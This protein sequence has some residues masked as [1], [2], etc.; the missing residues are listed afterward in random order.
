MSEYETLMNRLIRLSGIERKEIEAMPFKGF[1]VS[2]PEYEVITPQTKMS[3]HVRSLNVSEEE[4]LKGSLVTPQ[5]VTEHLNK[6][7]F[8]SIVKKPETITDFKSFLTQVTLK[9]R[10]A[11][12]YGLY[13]ITY[14]EI[15]NYDIR[16]VACRKTFP[17]TVRASSTFNINLYPGNDILSKRVKV[18][19]PVTTGVNAVIRQPRL[20]DEERLMRDLAGVSIDIITELLIIDRF[21][22]DIEE[23]KEPKVYNEPQ[24]V[25][26]AFLTL[27]AKDKRA[28]HDKYMEEFGQYGLDLKMQTV[29][30]FCG[31]E[32]TSD[33][34][35][36]D[37]FFRMVFGA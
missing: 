9:D 31:Q 24:D 35:L 37:N 32:E 12:L 21:E 4:R 19:L 3:F 5:R 15:R 22:Q 34:D 25:R 8:D 27:P 13:H 23:S 26:D 1:G 14:E 6:C 28:I 16:C 2:Y 11:I 10:D 7:L 30:S 29:C 20:I 17:V 36:V 18:P 33:I